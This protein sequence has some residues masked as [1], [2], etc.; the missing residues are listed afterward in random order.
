MFYH[1]EARDNISAGVMGAD[2]KIT[3]K[4]ALQVQTINNAYLTFEEKTKGW[5]G[6]GK[7]AD[8][9]VLPEDM[10]TCPARH[11]EQ[12]SVA[13]TMVGGRIVYRRAS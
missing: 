11:I 10:L 7:L 1:P 6:P 2:Q 4:E 5:I 3:R 8:L 9:V 13:M 12:M